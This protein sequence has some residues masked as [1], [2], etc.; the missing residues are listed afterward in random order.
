MNKTFKSMK[1][2]CGNNVQDTSSEML[3][4]IGA[5][6]NDREKEVRQR[7]KAALIQTSRLDYVVSVSTE[8]IVL[9]EDCGNIVSVLDKTNNLQI[10][11][12]S[13]QQ[14]VNR[15]YGSIDTASTVN[16]YFVTDSPVRTQPTTAGVVTV[17]SDSAA[18]TT[19]TIYV[20]MIDSNGRSTDESITLTG[21]SAASGSISCARVLGLSK[22]AITAGSITITSGSDTL[23]VM[24]PDVV[25]SRVKL[26]R[27]AAPP[28]G[29]FTCEIIY[30]QAIL[31]MKND[32][33]YPMTDC[34]DALE[35]GATADAW[36]FKRQFQKASDY[37]QIF[38]KK[39]AN[40]A[41]D[42]E[43]HPNRVSMMNPI[44]YSRIT[45]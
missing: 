10:E 25:T 11:E 35:A 22:S 27:F 37:E 42:Y 43:M 9:P 7:L 33:D 45:T 36:R 30:I 34:E 12:I 1:L 21:T 8:D 16:S 24:S 4:L 28:T 18:D 17:V 2:A 31:P 29:A 41:Y 26:L 14:W 23:A 44:A 3:S 5:Y 20:K 13:E 19:Q 38:E 32:Y 39:L 6:L 15:N 40:I